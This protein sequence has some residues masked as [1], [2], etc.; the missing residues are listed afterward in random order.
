VSRC[1]RFEDFEETVRRHG[2][3]PQSRRVGRGHDASLVA[4]QRFV[5]GCV[6][7]SD[8]CRNISPRR[9]AADS[10]R[11][12]MAN[13]TPIESPAIV[14]RADPL[15][16]FRRPELAQRRCWATDRRHVDLF[17]AEAICD[18]FVVPHASGRPISREPATRSVRST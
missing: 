17:S 14:S 15:T 5:T 16:L 13:R 7:T 3:K 2:G 9:N 11:L 8:P 1:Y 18:L 4:W 6:G 10:L 12:R